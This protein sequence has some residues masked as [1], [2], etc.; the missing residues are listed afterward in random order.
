MERQDDVVQSLVVATYALDLGD[1]ERARAAVGAALEQSRGILSDLAV[2]G[3]LRGL[4]RRTR[5]T[6]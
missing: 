5:P 6:A 1:V 4:T 3:G 2:R